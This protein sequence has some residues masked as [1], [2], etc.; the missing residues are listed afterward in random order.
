MN[1]FFIS[2]YY[3]MVLLEAIKKDENCPIREEERKIGRGKYRTFFP[4]TIPPHL[5]ICVFLG[6]Y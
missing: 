5:C 1:L 6:E 3:I 2:T 4:N